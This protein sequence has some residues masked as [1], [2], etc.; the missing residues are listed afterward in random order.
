MPRTIIRSAPD[1]PGFEPNA[2]AELVLIEAALCAVLAALF[3]FKAILPAWRFLNTDFPNYYLVARLLRE[4]YSLD[5]IYDWIWLQ[6]IKDHWGLDQSLVGFAGLTPFSALPIVPLSFFSALTAKRVW[7][8]LNL[9]FLIGSVELLQRSTSLGRRRIWLLALLAILPLRTSFL[10]GQMHL[11]VLFLMV[12]AWYLHRRNRELACGAAVALAATLKVYP[13]LFVLYFF[14]KRQWRAAIATL[15]TALIIVVVASLWMGGDL[16]RVYALQVLPRSLQGETL[17]PYNLQAAS[18]SALF[19]RLF[20]FELDLNPL[21]AFDSPTLYSVLYPLWQVA[22][23]FP[24]F[25]LLRPSGVASDRE[26]MGW[27]AFL[28]ALLVTSPVP[29]SYHFAMMILS[30]VLLVDVLLRR[31]QSILAVTATAFYFLVIVADYIAVA[32]SRLAP[33]LGTLFAFSRLWFAVAFLVFYLVCLYQDSPLKIDLRL[34]VLSALAI[35]A[36]TASISSY[37]HHFFLRSQ[38][39]ALRLPGPSKAYLATLPNPFRGGY[40]SVAMLPEGYRVLDQKSRAITTQSS[41]TSP[42][43]PSPDQLSYAISPDH[44]VLL[45]IA[46]SAGSRILHAYDDSVVAQDAE[47]PAISP[48]GATLAFLREPKGRGSLWI[49]RMN[50]LASGSPHA[51][52]DPPT[53]LTGDDYDVRSVSFLRSGALLFLAKHDGQFGLYSVKPGSSPALFFGPREIASFAVSPDEDRIAVTALIH[54]RWQL[55]T[56]DTHSARVTVLTRTDCNAYTPAWLNLTTIIYAT[57][58]GRGM[59]LTAL[60]QAELPR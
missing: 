8:V 12:L 32:G 39:M 16:I 60:A 20:L 53:R 49:A 46:D 18:A 4:G 6:R 13:L 31:N 22:I 10:Y 58:C 33:G 42:R 41:I 15:A 11:L 29:S 52:S 9:L 48:D 7:I 55:A 17:D 26:Q 35:V 14:W 44:S 37:R 59:G 57:D 30:I 27:G 23:F 50:A 38:E 36:L 2:P 25:A 5:R 24:L 47:S 34:A 54:N 43:T 51:S 19:H 3:I 1:S 56:L 28:L 40:L 21:P 45:E